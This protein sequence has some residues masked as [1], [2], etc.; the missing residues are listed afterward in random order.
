MNGIGN[1]DVVDDIISNGGR[2]IGA[3]DLTRVCSAL[4]DT[5]D[6][7]LPMHRCEELVRSSEFPRGALLAR[8]PERI[9]S[10]DLLEPITDATM[11]RLEKL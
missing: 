2:E 5:P 9:L 7:Q 8:I 4:A 11:V 1:P 3:D 10:V 6:K